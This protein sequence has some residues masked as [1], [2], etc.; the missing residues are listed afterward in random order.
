MHKTELRIAED[1]DVM[2]ANNWK[3]NF[4]KIKRLCKKVNVIIY[5]S[6]NTAIIMKTLNRIST[7]IIK[8]VCW[9][10]NGC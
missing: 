8:T 1:L 9:E 6:I 10:D 5:H 3:G 2:K 4:R 7:N